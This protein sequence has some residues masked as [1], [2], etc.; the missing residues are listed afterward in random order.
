MKNVRTIRVVSSDRGHGGGHSAGLL[1]L[2]TD[3]DSFTI[4]WLDIVTAILVISDPRIIPCLYRAFNLI[5][6]NAY[7]TIRMGQRVLFILRKN[8]HPHK[9]ALAL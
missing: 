6:G 7:S 8:I 5:A 2:N 9:S 3:T 4:A 1:I